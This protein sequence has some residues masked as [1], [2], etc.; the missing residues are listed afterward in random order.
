MTTAYRC[1]NGD[2]LDWICWK[3][4]GTEAVLPQVFEANPG[5]ADLGTHM[6]AGTLVALPEVTAPAEP[7]QVDVWG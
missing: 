2:T 4:Y 5:L 3:Y 6:P 1:S 7:D